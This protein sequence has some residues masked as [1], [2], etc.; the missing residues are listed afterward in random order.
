[1]AP[2]G[3]RLCFVGPMV[4]RN[5][6]CVTHQGEILADLFGRAGYTVTA[7]SSRRNRYHRMA[8]MVGTLLA[9]ARDVD[10]FVVQI[11]GEH[12]FVVEDVVS[13]IGCRFGRPIV[14]ALHGGTLPTFMARYPRWSRRVFSRAH[15]IVA[16][17]EFLAGALRS[18]G[19]DVRVIPNVL[20]LS[21]YPYRERRTGGPRLFW[22]RAFCDLYNP[23]L[24][25]QVLARLRAERP[26]YTLVMAGSDLGLEAQVRRQA[27]A[28]GLNG[29][30]RFAGFLDMAGKR[31]EGDHADVFINTN[32][33]D[34]MPVAILEACAMG[35][36]VVST[37]VGGIPDLLT[38]GENAL[39]VPPNDAE[40]MCGAIR[41]LRDEP[42]LAARLSVNARRLAE[43]SAW[44]EV[45]PC[46]ESVFGDALR[47]NRASRAR[48]PDM[49]HR[50]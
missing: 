23:G 42:G 16:P 1:M 12:S 32:D 39:L 24:A 31:R 38:H 35:L 48:A 28:C 45:K 15:V 13:W 46:W 20:D 50:G 40:A 18:F 4:G 43:R 29:S 25:I 33:V 10:I 22:M 27:V 41:C 11:Y 21:A 9:Y 2:D 47:A 30:V 37:C 49:Q 8:E 7:V 19:F 5:P 14:M 36:P 6:G 44:P 26:D 34:N 3:P 17:S